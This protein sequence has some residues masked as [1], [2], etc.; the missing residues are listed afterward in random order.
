MKP[1]APPGLLLVATRELRW[2]RRDGVALFLAVGVPLIAFLLLAWIFSSAV[3]RDLRVAVVDADRSPTSTILVQAIEASPATVIAERAT[4]LTA[5]MHAI[6]AG[7][8]IGAVYIPPSFEHDALN[9]RRPQVVIFYNTQYL[10]PGNIASKGLNEAVAAAA[11]LIGPAAKIGTGAAT[12]PL[13]VEQYVLTNPALN[14]AQ[15]LLRAILPTVLHIVVGLAAGYAVG[16]EL[17]R[18]SRRAWLRAAGGSPLVALVGKLMPLLG[19]FVL[20]LVVGLGVIHGLYQVPFR[21]DALMMAAAALLLVTAY[22]ALGALLPLLVGSLALG[23]S[24]IGLICSPAFGFAGIGFPVLGMGAFARGWGALLPLRWYSQILFDQAARGLP[25][26]SSALPF[27]ILLT[28]AALFFLLAWLRLGAIARRPIRREEAGEEVAAGAGLAGAF[29]AECRRVLG[30]RSVLSMFIIAPVIYGVYYPQPYL[31]QLLRGVPIAVVD[32]DRTEVSRRLIET[33]NADDAVRVMVRADTLAEA[34]AALH[35]RTVYGIL[36]IPNGTERE[37]LKGRS[38]R[39]PAYADS[40]YF[41][42]F[43]RTLQGMLEAAGTVSAEIASR[44]VRSDSGLAKAGL[45]GLQ[46]V[47]T[48]LAPLFNPTGGYASYVVPA[49]FVLILQQLLLNGA[50]TVGGVAFERG[51][52]R[53]RALRGTAV[54]ALGHGLAHL[55]LILPGLAL[56][57]V[58]L[59]RVYGFSTLGRLIDLFLVAVP[60][61]LSVSFLGQLAGACFKRRETA[62][63]LFMAG[64]LP[65]FFMVG[66]SWPAEAIPPLLRNLSRIF[67][68]TSAIDAIVRLDQMGASLQDVRA[69]WLFLWGTAGLFFAL[70]VVLNR[71]FLAAERGA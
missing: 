61:V 36:E 54:A 68:S 30:D 25:V 19:I 34:Q 44:G 3:V 67:P 37:V 35:A 40:A 26:A 12:G 45:A 39:L 31:G 28:L 59:P 22:L 55:C 29:A 7:D 57:L 18:R 32:Q 60:F 2:M 15:F 48:V 50:A 42:L 70:I 46:P 24:L 51:G 63:L 9:G 52:R 1:A 5:A 4:D 41:L 20:M 23:L 6:R 71:A 49:A 16:S 14:Y 65:L 27:L 64:G 38:A 21:G 43:N 47:E 8:A 10:T 62:L 13:V 58:V 17:S 11:S 33:L 56:Y 69:D 66:V 53:A